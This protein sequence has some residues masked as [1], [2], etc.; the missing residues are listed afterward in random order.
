MKKKICLGFVLAL[1]ALSQVA[2]VQRTLVATAAGTGD[3]ITLAPSPAITALTQLD[4]VPPTQV[5]FEATAANTTTVTIAISGLT[6]KALYKLN[7]AIN[8][9]LAANDIRV[10]QWVCAKRYVTGDA[11]QMTTPT[12]N[13]AS[14]GSGLIRTG[15]YLDDG[16]G[17]YYLN[18]PVMV[19]AFPTTT[20]VWTAF[21]NTPT[22]AASNTAMISTVAASTSAALS[23]ATIATPSTP[24]TCTLGL[25][26]GTYSSD[27]RS[28]GMIWSDGTKAS[29][30]Q[31]GAASG[32]ATGFA[33]GVNKW[34][35]ATHY[36]T[37]YTTTPTQIFTGYGPG[38]IVWFQMSDNGTNRIARYSYDGY[39]FTQIHSV[40]RTDYLTPTRIGFYGDDSSA[41]TGFIQTVVSWKC[42]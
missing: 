13:A 40:G 4:T 39:N 34:T 17:N 10:G 6:A 42:I 15:M 18:A 12:G 30:L 27:Y 2:R 23:G 38:Q 16:A 25:I 29:A 36:D 19:P 24:Y 8:T 35:D 11:F 41:N 7:G 9:A 32:S 14:G 20:G 1:L 21:G 5:C 3:A 37:G 28:V 26:P 33:W 22:L 31:F